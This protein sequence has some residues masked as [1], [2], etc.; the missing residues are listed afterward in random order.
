MI[1]ESRK[2][3]KSIRFLL[4]AEMEWCSS[5][6][7]I[8]ALYPSKGFSS[9]VRYKARMQIKEEHHSISAF[10]RN[11]YYS[12]KAK[13]ILLNKPQDKVEGIIRQYSLSLREIHIVLV[14]NCSGDYQ[15]NCI[16][17][18]FILQKH[19]EIARCPFWKLVLHYYNHLT[20]DDY[21]KIIYDVILNQS[22]RAH[23]YNHLSYYAK[24][25]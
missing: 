5:L 13:W 24:Y 9:P 11:N 3:R 21:S 20:Q 1:V 4:N 8:L 23:L 22:E 17:F 2:K 14:L 18:H 10:K 19:Q 25:L 16:L 7:Y 15:S 12:P 6:I